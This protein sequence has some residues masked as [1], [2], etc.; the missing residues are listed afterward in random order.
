MSW[1]GRDLGTLLG[2]ILC[3]EQIGGGVSDQSKPSAGIHQ[4]F[5][6]PLATRARRG[7][8]FGGMEEQWFPMSLKDHIHSWGALKI[9]THARLGLS[10]LY[11][12]L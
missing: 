2:S 9:Q 11:R 4:T 6:P 12:N 1:G 5:L 3:L 7:T 10:F 8:P